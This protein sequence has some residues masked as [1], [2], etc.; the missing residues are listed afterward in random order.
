M[1]A[2]RLEDS[3]VVR[4]DLPMP[5]LG[6]GEALVRLLQAGICASDLELVRGYLT[7]RGTLGN[8]F[9]GVGMS[10]QRSHRRW[11][12]SAAV[13]YHWQARDLGYWAEYQARRAR[14]PERPSFAAG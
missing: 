5:I 12:I 14:Q 9:V 1:R 3:A 4:D 7:F 8:E 2:I 6:P 11:W 13:S 10:R